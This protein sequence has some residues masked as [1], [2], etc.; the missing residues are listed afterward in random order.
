MPAIRAYK[1][2]E[3]KLIPV[4][5]AKEVKAF[6]CPWTTKLFVTKKS[7]VSHL[8]KLRE[9]RMH[10]RA[11]ILRRGKVMKEFNSQPTFEAAIEWIETH[12]EFFFD[13]AGGGS[14]NREHLQKIRP[15]FGIKI[16][17]LEVNWS[18]MVS[19]SHN[20]PRG[21]V[22][23]WDRKERFPDGTLKPEGYP[24]WRGQITF[25]VSHSTNFGSDIFRGTGVNTGSGGGG[26]GNIYNYSVIFFD[27]DWVNISDEANIAHQLFVNG[28]RNEQFRYDAKSSSWS[29]RK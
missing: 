29:W 9:E 10:R 8:G 22:T 6:Q 18:P 3:G 28:R 11:R 20:A 26:G 19:N 14:F 17:K 4:T 16:L 27:A 21:G 23:N 25:Q 1:G 7:Y 2:S 24:G 12:P 13:Q 15:D 5:E